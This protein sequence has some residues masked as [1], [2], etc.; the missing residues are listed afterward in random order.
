MCNDVWFRAVFAKAVLIIACLGSAS[1]AWSSTT[2]EFC[3]KGEFDLAL[4]L[5]GFQY[6]NTELYPLSWCITYETPGQRLQFDSAGH[7]NADAPDTFSVRYLSDDSLQIVDAQ[8][9]PIVNFVGAIVGAEASAHRRIDPLWI[10][11]ELENHPEYIV[12]SDENQLLV[13]YPESSYPVTIEI[14]NGVIERVITKAD[15]PMQGINSVVWNWDWSISPDRPQLTLSIGGKTLFS[16]NSS[17][18][19]LSQ[20]EAK[21]FWGASQANSVRKVPGKAW[22]SRISM[23]INTLS[24]KIHVITGVRTGFHHLVVE[25]NKGLVVFD[26]PAGWVE[27]QQ[28]P[29]ADL[30]GGLGVSGLSELFVDFLARQF[31]GIAIN[32]VLLS[33]FHADHAGGARA[34]AAAGAEVYAPK[35]DVRFLNKT[36]NLTSLP[37][38]RHTKQGYL[39]VLPLTGESHFGE[40][41]QRIEIKQLTGNPHVENAI[42]AWLSSIKL[43]YLSDIKLPHTP[44]KVSDQ[45]QK[46]RYCWFATWAKNNLPS[47]YGVMD[48]HSH[49]RIESD[50]IKAFAKANQCLM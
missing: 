30:V 18:R 34:F 47:S 6:D 31:P 22:P 35:E 10:L 19:Q 2:Q 7:I 48:S 24:P 44:E 1:L 9:Q 28:I 50:L 16:A 17:R 5:Q 4:R 25:T 26:A 29:P 33:H 14:K 21:L 13:R 36:L 43:L 3:L 45:Q 46:A 8:N 32:A 40:G 23:E 38:D 41:Q 11:K 12:S 15:F 27:I 42:A 39:E 20:D 49:Q 37:P